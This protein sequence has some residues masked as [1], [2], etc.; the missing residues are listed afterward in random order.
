MRLRLSFVGLL[1]GIIYVVDFLYLQR[2]LE[3][4]TCRKILYI[5]YNACVVL[6]LLHVNPLEKSPTLTQNRQ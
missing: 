1:I 4:R 3:S 2:G 6:R 5:A